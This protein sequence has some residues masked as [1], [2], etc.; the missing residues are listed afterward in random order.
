MD[1]LEKALEEKLYTQASK[2][3]DKVIPAGGAGSFGAI[4]LERA[5]SAAFGAMDLNH[6][7]TDAFGAMDLDMVG[8]GAFA[9]LGGL[10]LFFKRLR[11]VL[12]VKSKA[13]KQKLK[14]VAKVQKQA[15]SQAEAALK[16]SKMTA[17]PLQKQAL[18]MSANRALTAANDAK[19]QA[20]Q[21]AE[22]AVNPKITR[23]EAKDAI[24]PVVKEAAKATAEGQRQAIK[25]L[26]TVRQK[27]PGTW[28]E[29]LRRPQQISSVITGEVAENVIEEITPS[30]ATQPHLST[31]VQPQRWA[32]YKHELP[33]PPSGMDWQPVPGTYQMISKTHGGTQQ[34]RL[35]RAGTP[36]AIAP[37]RPVPAPTTPWKKKPSFWERIRAGFT[38]PAPPVALP[39]SPSTLIPSGSLFDRLEETMPALVPSDATQLVRGGPAVLP[40]P[41]APWL[42]GFLSP[43]DLKPS[44]VEGLGWGSEDA[45]GEVDII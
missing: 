34:W 9:G 35:V 41:P 11:G 20:K 24:R 30:A 32:Q 43:G 27:F 23:L 17:N 36:S 10:S 4:D 22:Q 28:R 42:A 40:E 45:Y 1:A 26:A 19:A 5:G 31:A 21:L 18:I 44:A 16:K 29:M 12:G 38:P 14:T 6:A 37:S 39:V 3:I 2:M 33:A 7:G 25:K 15:L 13:A 8:S